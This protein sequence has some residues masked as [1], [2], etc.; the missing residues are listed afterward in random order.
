MTHITLR[1]D[2]MIKAW[3]ELSFELNPLRLTCAIF[4]TLEVVDVD[5]S[6]Q[7][8]VNGGQAV[9]FSGGQGAQTD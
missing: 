8:L 4:R 7:V 2:E 3:R 1:L 6:S 9:S 5:R